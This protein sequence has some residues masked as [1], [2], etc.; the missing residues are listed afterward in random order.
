MDNNSQKNSFAIDGRV[1][2]LHQR[3]WRL[4]L[5][6]VATLGGLEIHYKVEEKERTWGFNYDVLV[7][8]CRYLDDTTGNSPCFTIN[9]KAGF[10]KITVTISD[11]YE[12]WRIFEYAFTSNTP[13]AIKKHYPLLS[14]LLAF[15]KL[16][17]PH[18][19]KYHHNS[20]ISPRYGDQRFGEFKCEMKDSNFY[21]ISVTLAL[22]QTLATYFLLLRDI[23][24]ELM[25]FVRSR[26]FKIKERQRKQLLKAARQQKE[27]AAQNTQ[28]M[29]TAIIVYRGV[30]LINTLAGNGCDNDG[31]GWDGNGLDT[32]SLDSLDANIMGDGM[33][34]NPQFDAYLASECNV[35]GVEID[36]FDPNAD[37]VA[38]LDANDNPTNEQGETKEVS[39]TGHTPGHCNLCSCTCYV[40]NISMGHRCTN[41]SCGHLVADHVW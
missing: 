14:K 17:V 28:L 18:G 37:Y 6:K 20:E 11:D 22:L 35:D 8:Q 33:D 27:K 41:P 32:M 34:A 10:D 29:R 19:L 39:F 38:Q 3:D 26:Y 40:G 25:R 4:N 9:M 21:S 5:P 15:E 31:D 36:E 16:G 7:A 2:N 13:A 1:E 23:D 30:K 24:R 12:T